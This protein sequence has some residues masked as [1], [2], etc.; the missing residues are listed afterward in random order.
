MRG[1]RKRLPVVETAEC[2][3]LRESGDEIRAFAVNYFAASCDT[4]KT[5][6]EF[7]ESLSLDYPILSDPD[8]GVAKSYG[9][10]TA[11]RELPHRWTLL[12]RRRRQDPLHRQK[13][14]H[15]Q[16]GSG[17]R[18]AI[19]EARSAGLEQVRP[20]RAS[21][22]FYLFIRVMEITDILS[23]NVPLEDVQYLAGH[24]N[25]SGHTDI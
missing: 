22:A 16:R 6:K 19:E 15:A 21:C 4:V 10:V 7:A 2:K 9:V 3:S 14:Q 8:K 17:C 1:F 5:N 12:C 23:Q 25:P 24:S 11:K 18:G 13:R 20:A